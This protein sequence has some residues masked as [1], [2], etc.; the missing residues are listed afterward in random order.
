LVGC[1]GTPGTLTHAFGILFSDGGGASS[2][3]IASQL[4]MNAWHEILG[5]TTFATAVLD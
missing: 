4:L 3:Q 1:N 2:T 5:E